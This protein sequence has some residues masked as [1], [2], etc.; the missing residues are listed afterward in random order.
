MAALSLA[1]VFLAINTWQIA[2]NTQCWF[3]AGPPSNTYLVFFYW[4]GALAIN[5][6]FA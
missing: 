1:H 5:V 4:V 6:P 2:Y 3:A